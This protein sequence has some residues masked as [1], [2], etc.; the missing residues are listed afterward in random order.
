MSAHPYG[1]TAE[2]ACPHCD[3][4]MLWETEATG[5]VVCDTCFV[6]VNSDETRIL[7]RQQRRL[8][9]ER[10]SYER[11]TYENS[12]RTRA[13]G[14]YRQAYFSWNTGPEYAI[15][16]YDDVTDGLWTPHKRDW[17]Y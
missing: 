14:G 13:L 3:N 6:S 11:D 9:E 2:R 5:E 4:G 17:A 8:R 12:G 7:A 15:D 16:M 10:L 1:D